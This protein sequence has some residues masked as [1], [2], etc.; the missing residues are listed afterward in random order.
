MSPVALRVFTTC[1]TLS[2]SVVPDT[3]NDLNDAT[4]RAH[5]VTA[6][7]LESLYL[8]FSRRVP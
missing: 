5:H 6:A 4:Q 3:L 1:M 7:A 2:R 8:F